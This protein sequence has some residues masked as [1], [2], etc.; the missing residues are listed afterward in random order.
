MASE[1][2]GLTNQASGDDGT[3]GLVLQLLTESG[4][5]MLVPEAPTDRYQLV[6]DYLAAFIHEQQQPQLEAL[7]A[8]LEE[9]KRQRLAAESERLVLAEANR[10]AERRLIWSSGLLAASLIAALLAGTFATTARSEL[11]EAENRLEEVTS[12]VEIRSEQADEATSAAQN[13]KEAQESALEQYRRAQAEVKQAAA[14]LQQL[15][16]DKNASEQQIAAARQQLATAEQRVTQAQGDLEQAQQ[17]ANVAKQQQ[18]QANAQ[19]A[20]AQ[21]ERAE[22]QQQANDAAAAGER[23]RQGTV[24]EQEGSRILRRFD[25]LKSPDRVG[26]LDQLIA[27]TQTGRKLQTLVS[28]GTELVDYAVLSPVYTLNQLLQDVRE[29]NQFSH[30]DAVLSVAFSPD[31]SQI[32]TGSRDGTA[33][34]W[35]VPTLEELLARSCNWLRNYLTHNPDISNED[36][37]LCGILPREGE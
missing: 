31:G 36:R 5:V 19:L 7:M 2:Q 34:L 22:A 8:E 11:Q 21:R 18:D 23:A 24:L 30:G 9:E 16:Q 10:K 37:A 26:Q 17:S 29:R 6:H 33:T 12:K 14:T 3:F 15:E 1:L 27:A 20:A 32:L 4:L 28:P 25:N 13:A 35:S